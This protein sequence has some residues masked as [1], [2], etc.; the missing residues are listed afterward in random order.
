MHTEDETLP[1]Y[2]FP[3]SAARAL[4]VVAEYADWRRKPLGT[5]PE[6]PDISIEKARG[7]CRNA[8]ETRGDGWLSSLEAR[9]VLTAMGLPLPPGGLAATADEAVEIAREVGFP[10]AVKVSSTKVV[11][12]TE[13]GGV[14]LNLIGETAVRDAFDA[15]QHRM[16]R[17]GLSDAVQGVLVQPMLSGSE[18]M[19][20]VIQDRLF[21]P[22]VGFGLG[23]IHVEVLGDVVFRVTPVTDRD[24]H[25][26]VRQIRG[27]RLLEGYR[28]HP[29]A[30]LEAL[31]DVLLRISRLAEGVPEIAEL[32]LNPLFALEPGK[33]CG[34]VD[35]R[36]R[37]SAPASGRSD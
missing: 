22:L 16:S 29:P 1:A 32:D 30:D 13:Y 36:I 12:K 37:V 33:G 31:E 25:E 7:V 14:R 27:F 8:L 19:V 28:G 21:G 26:M 9:D 34:I 11:H 3:E 4:A 18:V 17:E 23:G 6:M 24:A 15:I 5:C 20:G 2:A 35:A 10:V